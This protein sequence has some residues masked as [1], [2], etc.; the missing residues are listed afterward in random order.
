MEGWSRSRCPCWAQGRDR[1]ADEAPGSIIQTRAVMAGLGE[2]KSNTSESEIVPRAAYPRCTAPQCVDSVN[3]PLPVSS[4]YYYILHC[5][6]FVACWIASFR[7]QSLVKGNPP[8]WVAGF[9]FSVFKEG[10]VQ[11][12]SPSLFL[13]LRRHLHASFKAIAPHTGLGSSPGLNY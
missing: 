6:S 1:Y 11:S 8:R 5:S 12:D 3:S 10:P 13:S 4:S 2:S 9:F 7:H